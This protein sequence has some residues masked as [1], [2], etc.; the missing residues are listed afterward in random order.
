MIE[1]NSKKQAQAGSRTERAMKKLFKRTASR[2]RGKSLVLTDDP[3][4]RD[5]V[6]KHGLHVE[7]LLINGNGKAISPVSRIE[8]TLQ[9]MEAADKIFQTVVVSGLL[10]S[11][12]ADAV[13]VYLRRLWALLN[14]GGRLILNA[15]HE[16]CASDAT[17]LRE[18]DRK[19][20]G[21]LLRH[22]GNPKLATD[23]PYSWITM[24]VVKPREK[25]FKIKRTKLDRLVATARICRG[26]VIELG[27]GEGHL[28][29]VIRERGHE[30]VG[31][32]V[33]GAKIERA[34]S[35]HRDV[36]FIQS[37]ICELQG[38]AGEFDT[39]VLAE[40][41]EHV[42]GKV[43]DEMLRLAWSFLRP[44]GRLIVSV[45]NEDCI[46]HR[47]HI[48]EFDRKSLRKLLKAL[49]RPKLVTDQPFKWLMMYVE[50]RG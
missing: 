30:V 1:T 23:Q 28:C 21:R 38:L 7:E 29:G 45:P 31:V 24:Y 48:R 46:P 8:A 17:P 39:A 13:K 41:L 26:K 10:E 36:T 25:T 27:C 50:K 11:L 3:I 47:N 2:C 34:R 12:D 49:G 4:L 16:G 5:A 32:D 9:R 6:R 35:L 44:G 22:F 40:V 18:F 19:E 42:P 15:R 14:P 33:N 43:G 37:D 20:V